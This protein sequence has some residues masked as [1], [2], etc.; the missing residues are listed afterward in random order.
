[1]YRR[2]RALKNNHGLSEHVLG[3]HQGKVPPKIGNPCVAKAGLASYDHL[4]RCFMMLVFEGTLA[5]YCAPGQ[6]LKMKLLLSTRIRLYTGRGARAGATTAP[7]ATADAGDN[8][9]A[10]LVS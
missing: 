2:F 10:R 7:T 4:R 8:P 1:M 6:R 3:A 9:Q 5:S